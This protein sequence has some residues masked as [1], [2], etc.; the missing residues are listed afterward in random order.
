MQILWRVK[1]FKELDTLELY[2]ILQLRAEI[3]VVEQDSPYQDIDGK[4]F[5]AYHLMGFKGKDLVAYTRLLPTNVS[6]AE[7]SIG[8][9]VTSGKVRGQGLGRELMDR[10]IAEIENFFGKTPIRIGAQLY[11]QKFY[12]GFGF[13]REGDEFLEDRIP[14][15]IMLRGK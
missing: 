3:F 11:L 1:T 9:V 4:D 10:S 7:V 15:I 14:H 13:V 12:E 5:K 2:K 8:R 6:Y